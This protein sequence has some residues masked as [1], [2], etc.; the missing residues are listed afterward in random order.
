MLNENTI[1]IPRNQ[2]DNS[3]IVILRWDNDFN[4]TDIEG[5]TLSLFGRN[6]SDITNKLNLKE[7]IYPDD[8]NCLKTELDY[9]LSERKTELQ[10]KNYRVLHL[11]GKN[12]WVEA[13]TWINYQD[14]TK[15]ISS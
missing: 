7:L 1:Q 9:Y 3:S 13:Y 8:F 11:Q 14:P 12:R 4:I 6:K 15:K 10:H 2:L 5:N